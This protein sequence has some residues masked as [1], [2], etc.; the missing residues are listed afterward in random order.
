MIS[1]LVW[2]LTGVDGGLPRRDGHVGGVG[3]ERRALH[4]GL[5]DALD[6]HGQLGEVAEYFRHL[7][8]WGK[9]YVECF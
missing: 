1:S 4:D 6:L 8:T 3:D 2:L 5:G 9:T 7:V